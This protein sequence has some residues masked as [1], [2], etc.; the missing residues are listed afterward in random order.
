LVLAA[1]LLFTVTK[2]EGS[3]RKLKRLGG[4][5]LLAVMLIA[6]LAAFGCGGASPVRTASPLQ[7]TSPVSGTVTVQA[8]SG[9][10]TH[11]TPITVT[12]N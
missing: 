5:L 7:G 8:T 2:P 6:L 10:L 3:R 9:S 4:G 1:G 12:L 11:S